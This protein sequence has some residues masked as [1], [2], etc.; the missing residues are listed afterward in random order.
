MLSNEPNHDAEVKENMADA[1]Q[2]DYIAQ[3]VLSATASS[4][5][6]ILSARHF[7]DNAVKLNVGVRVAEDVM[8]E[9]GMAELV[10][11]HLNMLTQ[12]LISYGRQYGVPLKVVDARTGE[13]IDCPVERERVILGSEMDKAHGHG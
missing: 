6:I 13:S 4:N 11:R 12:A 3:Q 9:G 7:P 2:L 5:V 1:L 10:S 8:A